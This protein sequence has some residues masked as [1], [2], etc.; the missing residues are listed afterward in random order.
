MELD[1]SQI[2]KILPHRFPFLL[3]DKV[4]ELDSKRII[5]IK[6][7]TVN[8]PFFTGHFPG[9]PVFPGVLLVEACAQASGILLNSL[10]SKSEEKQLGFLCRVSNFS[11]KRIVKPGDVLLIESEFLAS[12]LSV[13]KFKTKATVNSEIAGLG[14][15]EII[16]KK[17]QE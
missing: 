17:R 16:V 13:Y 2:Y 5:A 15:I 9:N 3:I 11:F 10:N 4:L 7:V 8:E 1:L 12:K 14:E 6:N